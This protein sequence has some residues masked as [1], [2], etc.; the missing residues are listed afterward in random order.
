MCCIKT[1]VVIF[2]MNYA[3]YHYSAPFDNNAVNLHFP[4]FLLFE[5]VIFFMFTTLQTTLLY[6]FDIGI[7]V[8]K[9]E[10]LI[11]LNSI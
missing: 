6:N 5:F 8:I 3:F 2:F 7:L 4:I 1:S 11:F 9:S 10:W